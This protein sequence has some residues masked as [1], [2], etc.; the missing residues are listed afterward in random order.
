MDWLVL[1]VAVNI[2]EHGVD[3]SYQFLGFLHAAPDGNGFLAD[4]IKMAVKALHGGNLP[5]FQKINRRLNL[6]EIGHA[7]FKLPFCRPAGALPAAEFQIPEKE[8]RDTRLLCLL[9][10]FHQHI[11]FLFQVGNP[12][13]QVAHHLADGLHEGVGGFDVPVQVP[14]VGLDSFLLHL[15][16]GWP[17]VDG[18][19]LVNALS[20]IGTKVKPLRA[21]VGF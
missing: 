6:V 20:G 19:D 16:D 18:G 8:F 7:A 14:D 17:H 13:F 21:V 1:F 4:S 5:C 3:G 15:A 11:P 10:C 2:R 12:A 9:P